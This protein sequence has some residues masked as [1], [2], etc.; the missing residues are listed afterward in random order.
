MRGLTQH[1]RS[2]R[3]HQ[4]C[5]H[6]NTCVSRARVCVCCVC[7]VVLLAWNLGCAWCVQVLVRDRSKKQASNYT[8]MSKA[9]VARRTVNRKWN[10][11]GTTAPRL[12]ASHWKQSKGTMKV[13]TNTTTKISL[14]FV[15][16]DG[17]LLAAVMLAMKSAV[18][19]LDLHFTSYPKGAIGIT[20]LGF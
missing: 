6:G 12:C 16:Q 5:L 1:N 17:C 20:Q 10:A 13:G 11:L 2:H 8:H 18:V 3:R 19:G 4:Q 9:M 14:H 7:G 15:F